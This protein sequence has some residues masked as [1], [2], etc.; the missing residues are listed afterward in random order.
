MWAFDAGDGSALTGI[1]SA[2]GR[3]VT[4]GG[5]R[6]IPQAGTVRLW[7]PVRA[8]ADEVAAWRAWLASAGDRQPVEQAFREVYRLTP[9]ERGSAAHSDRFAGA[10]LRYQQL[11]GL[12]GERGWT[13]NY[14]DPYGGDSTG[15][16]CR[17]FPDAR[18]TAVFE[19][20]ATGAQ[21]GDLQL[22]TCRAGRVTFCRAGDRSGKAVR[23][24]KVPDLV[25]TEALRDLSLVVSQTSTGRADDP[26]RT[27]S[28]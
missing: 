22:E 18:L 28:A 4:V 13:A 17:A 20:H 9:P 6:E 24:D 23:L 10:S 21:P 1:P 26:E 15:R 8:G 2:D 14:L 11:Y 5:V 7:H 12:L 19:H 25:F 3:L 16:A 27:M